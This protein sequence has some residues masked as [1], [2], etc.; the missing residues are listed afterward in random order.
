MSMINMENGW[1]V[2]KVNVG[3]MVGMTGV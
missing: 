3:G 2:G 1:T